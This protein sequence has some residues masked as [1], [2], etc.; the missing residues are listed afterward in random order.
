M[1]VD[2]RGCFIRL[3]L[4]KSFHKM[5]KA[6]LKEIRLGE[7]VPPC[8]VCFSFMSKVLNFSA[9]AESFSMMRCRSQ[10]SMMPSYSRN[11]RDTTLMLRKLNSDGLRRSLDTS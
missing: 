4:A 3:P 10:W 11:A 5:M 2:N 1:E 8:I 6:A 9:N 7:R